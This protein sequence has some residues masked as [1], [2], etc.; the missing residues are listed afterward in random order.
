VSGCQAD[1]GSDSDCLLDYVWNHLGDTAL[2]VSV[3]FTLARFNSQG[4]SILNVV[5]T[6]PWLSVL[7]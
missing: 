2:G 1:K 3:R 6:D 5:D 7:A 4:G